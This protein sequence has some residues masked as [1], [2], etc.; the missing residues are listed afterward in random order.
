[1]NLIFDIGYHIG[2]F[3]NAWATKCPNCK[4]I[5]L[6]ANRNLY[7]AK[8]RNRNIILLNY[9]VSSQDNLDIDFYIEGPTSGISTAS[10]KFTEYSRFAIG[11][12][13]IRGR[14]FWNYKTKVQ[15]ITLD[16][17]IDTYG[18]PDYIKI[19]VEGY[20]RSVMQGLTHKAGIIAFEWHEEIIEEAIS[21][22]DILTEV[23]YNEFGVIGYL[24]DNNIPEGFKHSESMNT[25]TEFPETYV[26]NTKLK[27]GLLSISKK[28]R[29]ITYGMIYAK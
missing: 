25:H 11:S 4:I 23:G 22:V 6:E 14:Y 8:P 9:L 10:K 19:D 16:K 3:A 27:S 7:L 29:R 15:S 24:S 20:E 28:E 26:S 18:V 13:N 17:L 2:R 12:D 5:G 1:M 21:C